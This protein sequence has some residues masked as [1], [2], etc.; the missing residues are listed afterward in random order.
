MRPSERLEEKL[1]VGNLWLYLLSLLAARPR[2]AYE[3]R[4]QVEKTYGFRPG[5]VTAYRVLYSLEL[6]GFVKSAGE[7]KRVYYSVTKAGKGE[8]ARG[9]KILKSTLGRLTRRG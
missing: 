5:E 6:A 9:R 2:Y 3:L 4:D 1:T 7:G 8:L